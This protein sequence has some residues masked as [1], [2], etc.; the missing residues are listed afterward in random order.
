M[1]ISI[2]D[3]KQTTEPCGIDISGICLLKSPQKHLW[4][5]LDHT[6]A[7]WNLLSFENCYHL[8]IVSHVKWP[9]LWAAL[10]A[11][12]WNVFE[13]WGHLIKAL[14]KKHQSVIHGILTGLQ[15]KSCMVLSLAK[16]ISLL[17][18]VDTCKSHVH[19]STWLCHWSMAKKDAA[20]TCRINFP[21][22]LHAFPAILFP[23]HLQISFLFFTRFVDVR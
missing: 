14:H 19:H 17:S 2:S 9:W 15:L 4:C 13:S 20:L 6:F 10:W 12:F 22:H 23:S 8:K 16:L 11:H 3:F 21:L 18:H 1:N 5:K 7:P